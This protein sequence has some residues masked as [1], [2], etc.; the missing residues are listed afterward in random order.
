METEIQ[1]KIN[2]VMLNLI[3]EEMLIRVSHKIS[4]DEFILNI[5]Q[6]ENKEK[7]RII[8]Y[9]KY[10]NNL[11]YTIRNVYENKQI[12]KYYKILIDLTFYNLGF[13]SVK[14]FENLRPIIID[15]FHDRTDQKMFDIWHK[16]KISNDKFMK[17]FDHSYYKSFPNDTLNRLKLVKKFMINK[18]ANEVLK[19]FIEE[20]DSPKKRKFRALSILKREEKI[21]QEY[22]KKVE[23]QIRQKTLLTKC[24]KII[25]EKEIQE[26]IKTENQ[27]HIKK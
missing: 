13:I 9:S 15:H 18:Y 10:T 3:N 19:D 27:F 24:Q 1:E 2:S 26:M 4:K 12:E 22:E 11:F 7:G 6:I 21:Q 8:V 14:E 16:Y 5:K 20:S 25:L 23:K 17:S